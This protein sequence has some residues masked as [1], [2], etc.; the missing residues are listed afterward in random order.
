[1][2]RCLG[3]DDPAI[4]VE[5]GKEHRQQLDWKALLLSR[6]AIPAQIPTGELLA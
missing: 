1:M 6:V 3:R 4:A 5:S 2:W